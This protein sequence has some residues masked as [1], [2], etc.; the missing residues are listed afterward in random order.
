MFQPFRLSLPASTAELAVGCCP[1]SL[2]LERSL[3]T[4]KTFCSRAIGLAWT[5]KAKLR[6][7]AS[8]AE[9][10]T[11]MITCRELKIEGEGAWLCGR[12]GSWPT[13]MQWKWRQRRRRRR[14]RQ[15]LPSQSS[16]TVFRQSSSTCNRGAINL[17][18]YACLNDGRF[19]SRA[20][21]TPAFVKAA[22]ESCSS[23]C[24]IT[25]RSAVNY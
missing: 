21:C 5:N 1:L 13:A 6:I 18:R 7:A 19:N 4:L 23:G 16:L 3:S 24:P 25:G 20:C 12:S 11:R 14:R 2:S 17:E 9:L 10:R 8:V 22:L 15:R